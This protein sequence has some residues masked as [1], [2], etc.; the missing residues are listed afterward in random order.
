[1]LRKVL[2]GVYHRIERSYPR[3]MRYRI[4]RK[5]NFFGYLMTMRGLGI[6]NWEDLDRSGERP[7]IQKILPGLLRTAEPVLLDVGAH[8][9][10]YATIL[11][12]AFPKARVV[13]FEA[14]PNTFGRLESST[15]GIELIHAAVSSE[16]GT[17]EL[18]D[19]A[20]DEGS[21]HASTQAGVIEELW[22]AEGRSWTVPAVT[23]EGWAKDA[24]VDHIGLLKIDVEGAEGAV[25]DGARSLIDAGAIDVIQVE[26]NEMNVL[27]RMFFRDLDQSLELYEWYRLLPVGLARM[28][29]YEPPLHEI[30]A[31]QNLVAVRKDLLGD[32]PPTWISSR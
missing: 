5:L 7:F 13:A 6:F 14:H 16:S 3:L 29:P 20:S 10:E 1:M 21:T 31:F 24:G 32:A 18:W 11:A 4:A 28:H 27:S 9:G 15:S 12:E 30:F 26:F 22:H 19:Y 8:D 25:L 17:I 2:R 23:I